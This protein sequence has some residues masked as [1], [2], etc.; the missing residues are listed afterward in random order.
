MKTKHKMCA[1]QAILPPDY[2]V[3]LK[4]ILPALFTFYVILTQTNDN[5]DRHELISK[6][7]MP[8][9]FNVKLL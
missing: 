8:I 1:C 9:I 5:D 6:L 2:P 4:N 3:P 7:N